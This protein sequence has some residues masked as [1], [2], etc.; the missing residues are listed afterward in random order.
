V[1]DVVDFAAAIIDLFVKCAAVTGAAAVVPS[2]NAVALLQEFPDDVE[3]A[4]IEVCMYTLVGEGDE[5]L[6][7]RTV[8][9][10]PDEGVGVDDQ[11]VTGAGRMRI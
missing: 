2:D 4:G 8:E 5:G 6:L 1:E 7:A 11:R 9:V 3:I 10:A